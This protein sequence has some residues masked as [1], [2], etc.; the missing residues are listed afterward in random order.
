MDDI[1]KQALQSQFGFKL[2]RRIGRGAFGEV[3]EARTASLPKKTLPASTA[4]TSSA[5]SWK[6]ALAISKF[7]VFRG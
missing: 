6:R 7:W 4:P 2:I 5:K 1:V 3:W